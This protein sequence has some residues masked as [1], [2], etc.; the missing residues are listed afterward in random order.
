AAAF[1]RWLSKRTALSFALPTEAQWEYAAAGIRGRTWA[2]GDTYS[3]G[4]ANLA[5]KGTTVVGHFPLNEHGLYDM[6]GNVYEWWAHR[7][8]P[9]RTGA[10][11]RADAP[12]TD[13]TGPAEGTFRVL[14]GGSW[15]DDARDG[16]CANRFMA[17]PQLCAANWG[18]RCALQ[19][20]NRL[21]G[22]LGDD[23]AL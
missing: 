6:T 11:H 23:W 2:F 21:V 1:C 4:K 13:P 12:T 22:L 14:R 7:S 9:P 17:A 10:G 18:F 8:A 3:A 15:F 5:G 19:I 16:R 20:N